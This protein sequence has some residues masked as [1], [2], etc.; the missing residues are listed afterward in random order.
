MQQSFSYLTL[1][2]PVGMFKLN[3]LKNKRGKINFKNIYF[4]DLYLL[5]LHMK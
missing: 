5:L 4:A 1:K 3:F 2:I